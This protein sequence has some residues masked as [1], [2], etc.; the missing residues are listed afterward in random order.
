[1]T[2]EAGANMGSTGMPDTP[3]L[4]LDRLLS[5]VEQP[6]YKS[7]VQNVREA[8]HPPKLP[9]LEVTSKPVPVKD[10]WGFNGGEK[11]KAGLSSILIHVTVVVS[12]FAIGTN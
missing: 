11:K 10:I 12:L 9:P 6:W 2:P 7:F 5:N 8:I 4:H 1:M 3:D